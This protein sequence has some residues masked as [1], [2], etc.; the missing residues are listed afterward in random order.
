M[1][2]PYV[3]YN[4]TFQTRAAPPS[5]YENKLG[6]ALEEAFKRKIHDLDGIIK[7]IEEQAVPN[8]QGA[9]WSVASLTAELAR[10]GT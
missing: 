4:E 2:T 1:K 9:S 5:D 10:L 7:V 3:G 6:D 8:P